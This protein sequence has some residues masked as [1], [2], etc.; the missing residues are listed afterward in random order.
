MFLEDGR[1]A[2]CRIYPVRP[3]RCRTW[4]FWPELREPGPALEEAQRFCPGIQPVPAGSR[5][6]DRGNAEPVDP[7]DP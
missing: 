3:E 6:A 2:G 1:E 5:G 4:P 7:I